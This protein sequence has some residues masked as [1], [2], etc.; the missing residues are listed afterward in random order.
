MKFICIWFNIVVELNITV[1][2]DQLW[3]C[4]LCYEEHKQTTLTRNYDTNV[5]NK[6]FFIGF[7]L[8]PFKMEAI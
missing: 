3:Y 6:I 5:S 4:N 8:I 7:T 1:L 2:I